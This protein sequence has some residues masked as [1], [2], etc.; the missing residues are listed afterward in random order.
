MDLFKPR[1]DGKPLTAD[2]EESIA[3]DKAEK[4]KR[5]KGK[6]IRVDPKGYGF[7]ISSE[8]P[9]ERIFFHWSSLRSN[10]LRFPELRRGMTVE[11][12]A[13]WQGLDDITKE[14]K[15]YKAI[16]IVVVD[17]KIDMTGI[18]EHDDDESGSTESAGQ[19]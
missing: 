14:N 4:E 5:I 16:R 10:T 12:V 1:K 11:F 2:T 15:G 9:F 17:Q 3:R 19:K 13:R 8:L 6:I 7:I 18:E